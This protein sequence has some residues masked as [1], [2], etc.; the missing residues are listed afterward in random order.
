LALVTGR[1][2][3]AGVLR[4]PEDIAP[5]AVVA[6]ALALQREWQGMAEPGVAQLLRDPRLLEAHKAML[7]PPRRP[8]LDPI[9]VTLLSA[10]TKVDEAEALDAALAELAKPELAAALGDAVALERLAALASSADRR[11]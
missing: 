10:R 6:R 7:P 4:T 2:W 11:G 3:A 8:H 5:P 9:D 1:R